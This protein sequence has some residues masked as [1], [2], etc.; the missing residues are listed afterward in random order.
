MLASLRKSGIL[1]TSGIRGT[2]YVWGDI[3]QLPAPLNN[4]DHFFTAAL[5]QKVIVIAGNLFDIHP[6]KQQT[7]NPN[8]KN[9]IRFSFGPEEKNIIMGLERLETMIKE[10]QKA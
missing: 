5:K 10:A 6:G 8:F 3:S 1:C 2:F 4:A 7:K 9:Y